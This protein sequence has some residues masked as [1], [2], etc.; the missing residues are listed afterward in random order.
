MAGRFGRTGVE[1]DTGIT[2]PDGYTGSTGPAGLSGATGV[3]GP[4]GHTGAVG[5]EGLQG[6]TGIQVRLAWSYCSSSVICNKFETV[7]VDGQYAIICM[8]LIIN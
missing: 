7:A 5:L 2:G 3:T 1:G 8:C 4:G 6:H